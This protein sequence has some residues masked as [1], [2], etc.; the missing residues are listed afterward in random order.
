MW[1]KSHLKFTKISDGYDEPT[2]LTCILSKNLSKI[3]KMGGT[4]LVFEL[5]EPKAKMEG[6]F[7]NS[8]CCYCYLWDI[9]D[10]RYL[11]TNERAFVWYQFY[12]SG[13]TYPSKYSCLE[14]CRKLLPA[15]LNRSNGDLV[16]V[17]KLEVKKRLFYV[18]ETERLTNVN[19]L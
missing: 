13:S 4:E 16:W 8:Y 10:D 12:S 3:K 9:K 19:Y 17:M 7:N 18:E 11:F 6:V 14:S 5:Q 15:S 2:L 1:D